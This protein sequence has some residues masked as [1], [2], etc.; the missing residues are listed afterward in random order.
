[1]ETEFTNEE[2]DVDMDTD[3]SSFSWTLGLLFSGYARKENETSFEELR[4]G[5]R[6]TKAF[7]MVVDITE[8]TFEPLIESQ[9]KTISAIETANNRLESIH[10]G[11]K[12]QPKGR[13]YA[14]NQKGLRRRKHLA[15]FKR[16]AKYTQQYFNNAKQISRNE[17]IFSSWS[18][19]RA[20]LQPN[21]I[22]EHVE[23]HNLVTKDA[24]IKRFF[25]V[26]KVTPRKDKRR[27]YRKNRKLRIDILALTYIQ[28]CFTTWKLISKGMINSLRKQLRKMIY[29]IFNAKLIDD[30]VII[31]TCASRLLSIIAPQENSNNLV[32]ATR[33]AVIFKMEKYNFT[34]SITNL[35]FPPLVIGAL[36]YLG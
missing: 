6:L 2:L 12:R 13:K 34:K 3:K 18:R 31:A 15:T 29:Y 28:Q 21:I 10:Y 27:H 11:F 1:M 19:A 23:V 35:A 36:T 16:A 26:T 30:Y 7:Y 22:D 25:G 5:L 4:F 9:R 8:K 24:P 14:S 17:K 20:Y 32:D 33:I